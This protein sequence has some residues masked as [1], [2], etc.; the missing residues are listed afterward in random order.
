MLILV[1]TYIETFAWNVCWN[2]HYRSI[3]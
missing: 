1:A 3:V 2:T